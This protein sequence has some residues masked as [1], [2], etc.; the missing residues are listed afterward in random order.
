MDYVTQIQKSNLN[1]D[2]DVLK[3]KV[4]DDFKQLL[5]KLSKG[6]RYDYAFILE[7][8]SFI[9]LLNDTN[10]NN[11]NFLKQFYLN[12]TWQTQF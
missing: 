9:E 6:Y 12:N 1:K 7:E 3:L 8:I 2:V 10:L 5:K 4:V 11:S